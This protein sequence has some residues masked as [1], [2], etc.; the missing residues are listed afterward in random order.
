MVDSVVGIKVGNFLPV[1]RVKVM[2]LILRLIVRDSLALVGDVKGLN[3]IHLE[4][5]SQS[6]LS[7]AI[8]SLRWCKV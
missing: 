5:I 1:G 2:D 6:M 8:T 4:V 7:D 3:L